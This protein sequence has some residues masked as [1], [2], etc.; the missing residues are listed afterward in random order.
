M[1]SKRPLQVW[2]FVCVAVILLACDGG[3]WPGALGQ[4]TELTSRETPLDAIC[5]IHND[6]EWGEFGLYH[7]PCDAY[8]EYILR[9]EANK[10]FAQHSRSELIFSLLPLITDDSIG[11]EVAVTLAGLPALNRKE[12][13]KKPVRPTAF[14]HGTDYRSNQSRGTWNFETAI[15]FIHYLQPIDGRI[16]LYA[17]RR[18]D[19]NPAQSLLK[20]NTLENQLA[21]LWEDYSDIRARHDGERRGFV[22]IGETQNAPTR[23]EWLDLNPPP[24]LGS[25][26]KFLVKR[27]GEAL[28]QIA[29][30][31]SDTGG[32]LDVWTLDL[33]DYWPLAYFGIWSDWHHS[34][35]YSGRRNKKE[36]ETYIKD[37]MRLRHE[38]IYAM[39]LVACDLENR[40]SNLPADD[41]LPARPF[42][43]AGSAL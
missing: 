11:G 27:Y 38:R 33:R 39:N 17:L 29:F 14:L 18:T 34:G 35:S 26:L 4:P 23:Q 28:V 30:L 5:R 2:G 7:M 20:E 8:H 3:D 37:C 32:A 25:T 19:T 41:W 12:A 24:L 16:P 10:F 1:S 6:R 31:P 40:R 21:I 43:D 15:K 9:D 22:E 36:H 42:V 13:R